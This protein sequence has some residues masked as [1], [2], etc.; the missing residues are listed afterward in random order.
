MLS[1]RD[2]L[3]CLCCITGDFT[4]KGKLKFAIKANIKLYG[5]CAIL[6][7]LVAIPLIYVK[8]SDFSFSGLAMALAQTA[9]FVVVILL[10]GH[11]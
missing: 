4:F 7:V 11:G 10:L 5:A 3:S 2:S 8:G 9:G 6:G 1:D